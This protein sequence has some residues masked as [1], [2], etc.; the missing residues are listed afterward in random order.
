MAQAK[1]Q[2][3]RALHRH[4]DE[5]HLR[6]RTERARAFERFVEAGGQ[7][8]HRQATFEA[9]QQHLHAGDPSIWGWPVWPP[10]YRDPQSPVVARFVESHRVDIEFHAYLQWQAELQLFAAAE[11]A[12]SA[13]LSVGLYADLAVSV[14]RGGAEVW[15]NQNLYAIDASIGAPP[16]AF[17]PHGQ[18]WGLPPMI[19]ARLQQ[20][21]YAPLIDTLRAN[22]RHAGALR[23]DHVMALLRQFWIPAGCSAELGTYVRYPFEDLLGLLALESHRN[24]CLVIGEDLGT[25]PDEVRTALAANDVLSYRVL[26]F[27]RDSTGAFSAPAVY[28]ERALATAS[29]HDLPTLAGWWDGHDIDVR[30]RCGLL[31]SE[32]QYARQKDERT[33]DRASLLQALHGDNHTVDDGSGALP[34]LAVQRFLART[35]A[36]LMVVQPE[37]MFGVREQANLPGTIDEHPNWQRKLPVPLEEW[38][39]DRRFRDLASA[40]NAARAD[41]RRTEAP[42]PRATYRLQLHSE[43]TLADATRLIPYLDALG[44]SHIY[45][46]PYLRARAGSRHGYDIVDHGSLNPEIGSLQDF[47]HFVGALRQ[48]GMGHI[49]DMVPNHMGV[50]SADN[51]WWMDV[52]ENGPASRYADFFD[53]D[54]WPNDRELAGRVLLPVLGIPYGTALESGEIELRFEPERGAIAAWYRAHRFPL[55]PQTY[56]MILYEVVGEGA[57]PE[58]I[59]GLARLTDALRSIPARDVGPARLDKRRRACERGHRELASLAASDPQL[60]NSIGRVVDRINRNVYR[61][62]EILEAQAYRLANWRVAFDEINYRRFFDI[63][64]L[65]ALRM[66]HRP[67]FEMTHDFMLELTASAM[68]DGLRIDHPD[69]LYDPAAYFAQLQKEYAQRAGL[70]VDAAARPLYVVAEKIIAPHEHLTEAWHV[71]GTT[72]YRYANA[73]N[74]LLVDSGARSRIDRIW[75]AFVGDE[76]DDFES[77]AYEARRAMLR[78]PLAAGLTVLANQA[79]GLA[80][81]DRHSRDHT[82]ASLRHGLAEIAACFPVYRTYVSR[83]GVGPQDRRFIDWAVAR[84]VQRSRVTDAS[85]IVFLRELLLAEP[86]EAGIPV[87]QCLYFAMRFQQ[88]TAP[89]AAKGIEDTALYRFNRLISLADVGADPDQFGMPVRAF[90]GASGDRAARWP[91][92]LLATST[93]D[94]KRSEDART[95]IDV[96]SEVPAAWRLTLRRWARF[97][98]SRKRQVDEVAAPSRNDEYLLYQTLI[99]TWPES[100]DDRAAYR[101]RVRQYMIKAVREAKVHTSWVA[102]NDQYEHAVTSFVDDILADGDN[103]FIEDLRQQQNF[104]HWFGLLNSVTLTI[105]KLTSPGVPDFYQGN[106]LLDFSLVDP[107]NRRPID[108]PLRRSLLAELETLARQPPQRIEEA[109]PAMFAAAD[110]RAKLW[111]A[112]CLLDSRRRH[113]ALYQQGDYRPLKVSGARAGNVV[114]YMRR[115]DRQGLLVVA[116]RLFTQLGRPVG[117]LPVGVEAWDD[118]TVDAEGVDNMTELTNALTGATLPAERPLRLARLLSCFPGAVLHFRSGL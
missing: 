112:R 99:G 14:D 73:V 34:M 4:F 52:L 61:L 92:T 46:S 42:I 86:R 20:A 103:L 43:F 82:L 91:S 106:E 111:V 109:L 27:E 83:E 25:V 1:F 39:A 116:G 16:D 118:T 67:A 107:D 49:A 104:F 76:A 71:H 88:F 65:A 97:N 28:P 62:H 24:E 2:V 37:D 5:H 38:A 3:L 11:F 93:H 58:S 31:A 47:N 45:C 74:G 79:L 54:W 41:L 7:S 78:G 9:L 87:E 113:R 66:E 100:G 64:E 63:N 8:L 115:F 55:D 80:R 13:R 117:T 56:P 10:E 29:T 40:L 33:S 102:V 26:L 81:S 6:H 21:G 17:N 95:R 48:H 59:E 98:R 69:G 32:A 19:P 36:A 110:G 70:A 75:R 15:A 85:V 35:P 96:L 108:Y 51:A 44:I 30:Q 12:R 105:V 114:A 101:D 77:I 68:I 22:M 72:G 50:M 57:A 53:I 18:N 60:V 84:A 23:I 94:N 90:H 89:V